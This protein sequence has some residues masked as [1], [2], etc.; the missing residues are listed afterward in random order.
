VGDDALYTRSTAYLQPKGRFI[1][2]VPGRTQGIYPFFM[3]QLRPVL[4]GGTPRAYKILGLTPSGKYAHELARWIED[5]LVKEIL[6]DSEY[7]LE[8]VVQAYE[9]LMT[10]RARG[11]IVIKVQD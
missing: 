8:D 4:L 3:H 6:I 2:I 9:K 10:R 7:K 5:G 11:K 1:E